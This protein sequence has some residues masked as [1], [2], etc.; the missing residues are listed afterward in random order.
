[1]HGA[2]LAMYFGQAVGTAAGA[3][4]L[5]GVAG[6]SAYPA[7]ALIS[8]PLFVASIVVSLLADRKKTA[9]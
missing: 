9:G 1:M 7:L 5:A 2:G 6:P 4:V 3:T 8:V